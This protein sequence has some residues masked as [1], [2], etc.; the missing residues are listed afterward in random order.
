MGTGCSVLPD[1]VPCSSF[2]GSQRNIKLHRPLAWF[3]HSYFLPVCM[4]KVAN[5]SSHLLG[6]KGRGE[7]SG[8]WYTS[9]LVHLDLRGS[10]QKKSPVCI[11]F[12]ISILSDWRARKSLF[13]RWQDPSNN[14]I[15][16]MKPHSH[17]PIIH[18]IILD[19]KNSRDFPGGPVVMNLCFY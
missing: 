7:V 9:L 6:T 16:L 14:R 2:T 4:W 17:L 15:L 5:T 10:K 12:N 11:Y 3:L 18:R 19:S 13:P 8:K 1:L